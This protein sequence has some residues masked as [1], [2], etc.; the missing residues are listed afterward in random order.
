[1]YC[2]YRVTK[3]AHPDGCDECDRLVVRATEFAIEM[4][5]SATQFHTEL[6]L[7]NSHYVR[8]EREAY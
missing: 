7:G 2:T 3:R 5:T 8:V 1:M 4:K 6:E